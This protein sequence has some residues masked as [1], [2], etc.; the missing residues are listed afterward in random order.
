VGT[1]F[2]NTGDAFRACVSWCQRRHARH[3]EWKK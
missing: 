2:G 1:G 3:P